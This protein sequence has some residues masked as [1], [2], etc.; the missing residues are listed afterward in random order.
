MS[1][2]YTISMIDDE[3]VLVECGPMRLVIR[4]WQKGQ[5]QIE[6]ARGAAEE[7]IGYLEQVARCRSVLIQSIPDIV[8]LQEEDLA[9]KMITAVEAVGDDDLTP[10]AAVAGTIADAVA[11]WLVG[12]NMDRVIVDNGGDIASRLKAGEAATVG[13][14]PRLDNFQISHVLHLDGS[15]ASW[16]VATSGFGGRS[17]TRGIA[18]AVTVLAAN[19]SVADAAATAIGN[20]CFVEDDS[21][22]QVP[23][24]SLDPNTDLAGLSVTTK[25]GELLPEKVLIAIESARQ[26]AE[27]LSQREIILGAFIALQNV[28]AISDGLKQ[29]IS[30]VSEVGGYR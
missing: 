26:K 27:L 5:P 23:A 14:R 28:F 22:I 8:S 9:A 24:E 3:S 16:G 25:V 17:R 20:A 6:V 13:I 11:D 21:F 15:Q 10:M 1:Y 29:Y 12:Q 2:E 7:S 4:A 19:A 18:S 30:P